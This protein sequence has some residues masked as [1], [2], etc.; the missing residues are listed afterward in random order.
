MRKT[1][2]F[3]LYILKL[4]KYMLELMILVMDNEAIYNQWPLDVC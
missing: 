3:E 4:V 1:S 2:L